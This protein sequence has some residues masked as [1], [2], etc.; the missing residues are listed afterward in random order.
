MH[1]YKLIFFSFFFVPG[2]GRLRKL[3]LPLI[4][5]M[6]LKF[7]IL[8]PIFISVIA[9]I[10]FKGLWAGLAAMLVSAA[11][12]LK[13]LIVPEGGNGAHN[14]PSTKFSFGVIK[15]HH[16]FDY[17]WHHHHPH[18]H[19]PYWSRAAVASSG[20]D[21]PFRPAEPYRAYY[22]PWEHPAPSGPP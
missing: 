13:A 3:L 9:L 14:S 17:G 15:P 6:K 22:S 18:H 5:G 12:G 19:D 16:L 20:P 7:A 11:L 10:S 21:Y 4:L 2:R 1:P 8:L